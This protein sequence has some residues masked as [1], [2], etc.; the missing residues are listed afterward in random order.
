MPSYRNVYPVIRRGRV[1]N[2]TCPVCGKAVSRAK[3]FWMT[4]NPW[5]RN[6]DGTVRSREQIIEALKAEGDAWVADFT[7]AKC[8]P[9]SVTSG[10]G[11]AS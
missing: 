3:T 6:E 2:G 1:K 4:E 8:R 5:N 11:E 9:A 7:H 10:S